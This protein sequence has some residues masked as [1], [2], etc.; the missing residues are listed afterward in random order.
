MPLHWNL[1]GGVQ[2]LMIMYLHFSIPI[3][4]MLLNGFFS[5][6]TLTGL[7]ISLRDSENQC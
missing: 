3:S 5:I 4:P 6:L 2:A 1:L 7:M